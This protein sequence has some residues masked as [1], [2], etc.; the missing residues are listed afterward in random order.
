MNDI[1]HPLK[2]RIDHLFIVGQGKV[3]A[4][5]TDVCISHRV[6]VHFLRLKGVHIDVV[7][8]AVVSNSNNQ[9]DT[10]ACKKT[11]LCGTSVKYT[12][13]IHR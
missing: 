7:E 4:R 9:S 10:I 6:H 5:K 1:K 13:H 11:A 3:H 12:N 2:L 8:I